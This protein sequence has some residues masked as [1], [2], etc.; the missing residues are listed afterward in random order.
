M[1][2]TN[3]V[4]IKILSYPPKSS[5]YEILCELIEIHTIDSNI[6]DTENLEYNKIMLKKYI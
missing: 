6:I 1:N 4:Q 3:D 2:G 5:W